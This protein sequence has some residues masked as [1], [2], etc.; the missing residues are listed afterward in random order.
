MTILLSGLN[1]P[2]VKPVPDFTGESYTVS[3]IGEYTVRAVQIS[4]GCSSDLV[5]DALADNSMA[6]QASVTPVAPNTYCESGN[7]M[8]SADG[9]G[10]GAVNGVFFRLV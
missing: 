6:P 7:G 1:G 4:S 5:T 3:N 9:D 10:A 8:V 2:A